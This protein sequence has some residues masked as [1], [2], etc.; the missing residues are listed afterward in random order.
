[1]IDLRESQLVL[2]ARQRDLI[3]QLRE[4]RSGAETR[5]RMRVPGAGNAVAP[6]E[7]VASAPAR[8]LRRLQAALDRVA[9]GS[10]GICMQ[11]GG[12]IG[13]ARLTADPSTTLCAPCKGEG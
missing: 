3:N 13:R 1:M 6:N 5:R 12:Q 4:H 8:Q 2:R 7:I 11:C 10:Y 9:D